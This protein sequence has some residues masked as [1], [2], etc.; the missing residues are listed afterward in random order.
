MGNWVVTHAC[1]LY[2]M[3]NAHFILIYKNSFHWMYQFD[4][5]LKKRLCSFWKW[6]ACENFTD[7]SGVSDSSIT[8]EKMIHNFWLL[9]LFKFK[10]SDPC[11]YFIH[12]RSYVFST[13]VKH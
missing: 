4:W 2:T 9:E 1:V 7:E 12:I 8:G 6:I 13:F 3:T 11:K 5:V 10:E